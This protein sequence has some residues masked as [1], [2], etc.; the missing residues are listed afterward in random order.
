L[1]LEA[2]HTSNRGAGYSICHPLQTLTLYSSSQIDQHPSCLSD[3]SSLYTSFR[4]QQPSA[5]RSAFRA[6][7]ADGGG[8]FMPIPATPQ[9]TNENREEKEDKEDKLVSQ[10]IHLESHELF[11]Q[12]CTR[13]NLVK[14]SPR[15]GL[16]HSCV[17]IGEGILRVW[18][19]WLAEQVKLSDQ[20]EVADGDILWAD[21]KK[22]V[23]L[24]VKVQERE[25]L[26]IGPPFR[27]GEE[28]D[29]SYA[30]YYEGVFP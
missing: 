22:S 18:R 24:R 3:L 20:Q 10:D 2:F 29:V 5:D 17:S 28:R 12:L 6:G 13:T 30:L 14:S 1:L 27:V 19:D 15:R 25:A 16:F 11:S 8:W 4:P 21:S 7:L 23:G 9:S 26:P